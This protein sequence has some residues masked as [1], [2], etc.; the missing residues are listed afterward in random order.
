MATASVSSRAKNEPDKKAGGTSRDPACNP[1]RRFAGIWRENP[2]FER[3]LEN[4][5]ELRKKRD[6]TVPT[7]K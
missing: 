6:Q 1:L 3:L 7:S 4:I 5:A 2:D